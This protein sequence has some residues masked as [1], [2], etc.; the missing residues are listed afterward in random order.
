MCDGERCLERSPTSEGD[1]SS[2]AVDL[3]PDGVAFDPP[4]LNVRFE[5]PFQYALLVP[6]RESGCHR[7]ACWLN[8]KVEHIVMETGN[9]KGRD[10]GK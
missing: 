4:V 5:I 3:L 10:C 1:L 6:W 8:C 7:L 2:K 9:W